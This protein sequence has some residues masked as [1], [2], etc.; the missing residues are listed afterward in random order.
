MDELLNEQVIGLQTMVQQY[1]TGSLSN[2]DYQA[3]LLAHN[4][5]V[6][7]SRAKNAEEAFQEGNTDEWL[8]AEAE[9]SF[10][11]VL[12]DIRQEYLTALGSNSK[13]LSPQDVYD[14]VNEAYK[15]NLK[16]MHQLGKGLYHHLKAHRDDV[17]QEIKQ[18]ADR[19]EARFPQIN[20]LQMQH[21]RDRKKMAN[22]ETD[23]F[24]LKKTQ[25]RLASVIEQQVNLN[26]DVYPMIKTLYKNRYADQIPSEVPVR[27]L[28]LSEYE[29][30][31]EE[32]QSAFQQRFSATKPVD[33]AKLLRAEVQTLKDA[34]A[35][36]TEKV[37][38]ISTKLDTSTT[39][40]S[41]ALLA[42]QTQLSTL[43]PM[44]DSKP[45]GEKVIR[46][47]RGIGEKMEKPKKNGGGSDLNIKIS[48]MKT[49][50][51]S[52]QNPQTSKSNPSIEEQAKSIQTQPQLP[53][54]QDNH[55]PIPDI[56]RQTF[57][58]DPPELKEVLSQRVCQ[59]AANSKIYN[60]IAF[61]RHLQ[62][63][64]QQKDF[65]YFEYL[66]ILTQD[67]FMVT[68]IRR[69]IV[70][71]N[72]HTIITTNEKEILVRSTQHLFHIHIESLRMLSCS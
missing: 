15:S 13:N 9:F 29:R 62:S 8:D 27:E 47:T 66:K 38:S 20:T 11:D 3:I 22:V 21:D 32:A 23:L 16:H 43:L 69:Q 59:E 56:A 63:L 5:D 42:I 12:R 19:V 48:E 34:N 25:E 14:A 52:I 45:K 18:F 26:T 40:L 55:F 1:A 24:A 58:I 54:T 4:E 37:D 7:K 36:L 10:K 67:I 33:Q 68:V 6:Q 31:K 64:R 41:D 53:Q 46:E 28:P 57:Q 60:D 17:S 49:K 30:I 51:K 2:E 70:Q 39:L 44:S 50:A 72:P 65:R 71:E 35:A 61:L